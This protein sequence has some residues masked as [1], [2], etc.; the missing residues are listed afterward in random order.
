MPSVGDALFLGAFFLALRLRNGLLENDFTARHVLTGRFIL[1]SHSIPHFDPFSYPVGA[2]WTPHTWLLD[3]IFASVYRVAGFSG[4]LVISAACIALTLLL[5][6][7]FALHRGAHPLVVLGMVCLAAWVINSSAGAGPAIFALPFVL[8]FL[9]ILD[10]FQRRANNHLRLLP[11]MMLIWVNLASGFIAGFALLAMYLAGALVVAA[12]SRDSARR[13]VNIS[14]A[15][16][17]A[18]VFAITVLASFINPSGPKILFSSARIAVN[19]GLTDHVLEWFSPDFH[20]N[21]LAE[22]L[23]L[24]IIGVFITS[25][26]RPDLFEAGLLLGTAATGLYASRFFLI[27]V[28]LVTPI[29]ACLISTGSKAL[30]ARWPDVAV[31][32]K[33]HLAKLSKR[34]VELEAHRNSHLF[35]WAILIIWGFMAVY[36]NKTGQVHFTDRERERLT[37]PVD[38]L[39]FAVAN[40]LSGNMFNEEAWGGYIALKLFPAHKVFID[41]RLDLSGGDRAKQY[42]KVTNV[43]VGYDR[44]LESNDVNWVLLKANRPLCRVLF[45]SGK[46]KLVFADGIA[47]ILV[48]NVPENESLI[49]K[50]FNVY[51]V[52]DGFLRVNEYYEDPAGTGLNVVPGP[53][54]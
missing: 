6:F 12:G 53:E 39:Q 30:P 13:Q 34:A 25:R 54:R 18:I 9:V 31:R 49:R 15:R 33:G 23:L 52:P 7:R 44:V 43:E 21:F 1:S 35:V 27:F 3:V 42:L 32:F 45:L 29:A 20:R 24:A 41:D 28:V 48:R 26:K 17:L 50:Y 4:L 38:A 51:F 22:I 2:S 46:W 19:S 16:T 36:A 5:M 14:K 40:D 8:G 10:A 37:F 47:D 11:A